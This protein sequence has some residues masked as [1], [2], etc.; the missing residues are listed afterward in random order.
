MQSPGI[1]SEWV[2]CANQPLRLEPE[3]FPFNSPSTVLNSLLIMS[4]SKPLPN[5]FPLSTLK[6]FLPPRKRPHPPLLFPFTLPLGKRRHQ[7]P[8]RVHRLKV[9]GVGG[10]Q[11]TH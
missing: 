11:V 3:L 8:V 7:T 10:C 2:E 9:V 5:S 4:T 1:H 6:R